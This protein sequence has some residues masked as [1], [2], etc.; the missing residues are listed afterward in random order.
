M[1]ELLDEEDD[2]AD[3]DEVA[4]M[5]VELVEMLCKGGLLQVEQKE[6]L[7]KRKKNQKAHKTNLFDDSDD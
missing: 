6:P 1:L 7:K 2:D 3:E 4:E 5:Q